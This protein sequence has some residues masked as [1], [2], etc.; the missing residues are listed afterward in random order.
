LASIWLLIEAI[1]Q[2]GFDFDRMISLV[3]RNFLTRSAIKSGRYYAFSS[4]AVTSKY[5]SNIPLGANRHYRL[6]SVS[7]R[8]ASPVAA[9]TTTARK[10]AT[11]TPAKKKTATATKNKATTKR[12]TTTAKKT[13][14]AA[15]K[16]RKVAAKRKVVKKTRLGVRKRKV[17]KVVLKKPTPRTDGMSGNLHVETRSITDPFV[18]IVTSSFSS[19]TSTKYLAVVTLREADVAH[20]LS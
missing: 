12:K 3:A 9:K 2:V 8:L 7:T 6:F 5:L 15:P 10:S 16:K 11:K 13:K 20:P 17:K 4:S 18:V 14:K 19:R 1:L